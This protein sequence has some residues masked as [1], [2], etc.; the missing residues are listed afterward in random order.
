MRRSIQA[1]RLGEKPAFKRLSV[2]VAWPESMA[3]PMPGWTPAVSISAAVPRSL[4]PLTACIDGIATLKCASCILLTSIPCLSMERH[5]AQQIR[6][7]LSKEAAGSPEA[8]HYKS[9]LRHAKGSSSP[10]TGR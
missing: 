8:G 1:K 4:K 6:S 3:S 7:R 2:A 10:T 9:S 5:V